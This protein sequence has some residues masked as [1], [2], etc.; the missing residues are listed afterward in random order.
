MNYDNIEKNIKNILGD[1]DEEQVGVGRT[2]TTKIGVYESNEKIEEI[3]KSI[4]NI[5]KTLKE[6]FDYIYGQEKPDLT[7]RTEEEIEKFNTLIR[8]IENLK[9]IIKEKLAD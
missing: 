3:R 5:N 7:G 9:N 2:E 8:E 4:A 1:Q 6:E